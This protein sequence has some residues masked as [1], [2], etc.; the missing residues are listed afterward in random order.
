MAFLCLY[1]RVAQMWNFEDKENLKEW[2][3]CKNIYYV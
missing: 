2:R 1:L 3:T